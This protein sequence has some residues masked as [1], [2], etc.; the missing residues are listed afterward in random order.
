MT[1]T[2]I[3]TLLWIFG[4]FT[5][6]FWIC[7]LASLSRDYRAYRRGKVMTQRY[8]FGPKRHKSFL[9]N[10]SVSNTYFDASQYYW[11]GEDW[12]RRCK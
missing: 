4:S 3:V 5:V 2:A 1:W 12:E 10:N 6:F 7:F 8:D 9:L 11:D